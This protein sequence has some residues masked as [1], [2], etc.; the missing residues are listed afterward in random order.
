[1]ADSVARP[2]DGVHFWGPDSVVAFAE[3]VVDAKKRGVLK[4]VRVTEDRSTYGSPMHFEVQTTD[5][6]GKALK[7][8]ND[9]WLCPPWP[10]QMCGGG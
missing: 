6:S 2:C 3:A 4:G 1:M 7:P 5:E 8:F 10:P 9:T